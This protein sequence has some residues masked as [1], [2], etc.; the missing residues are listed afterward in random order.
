MVRAEYIHEFENNSRSIRARFI[1]DTNNTVFNILTDSPD[2][3]Y[4]VASA[5]I[6]AQFIHGISLF[7][8]YDTVQAHS[9]INNHNF[10]GGMRFELPF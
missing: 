6:S 2:R 10:S 7:V 4:I 1:Q 3:D 5:G 8:N 9:Y